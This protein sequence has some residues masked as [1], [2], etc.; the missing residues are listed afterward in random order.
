L[1]LVKEERYKKNVGSK[2]R[3]KLVL[4][5]GVGFVFKMGQIHMEQAMGANI[6]KLL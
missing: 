2:K 6:I 3:F 4:I 5:E 1:I